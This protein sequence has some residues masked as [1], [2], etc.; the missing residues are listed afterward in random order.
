MSQQTMASLGKS[1]DAYPK[2]SIKNDMNFC[3]WDL[4]TDYQKM[5][6]TKTDDGRSTKENMTMY[7][8]YDDIKTAL[9]KPFKTLLMP[10]STE[11]IEKAKNDGTNPKRK[12]CDIV[13]CLLLCDSTGITMV[14]HVPSDFEEQFKKNDFMSFLGDNNFKTVNVEEFDG[15]SMLKFECGCPIKDIDTLRQYIFEYFKKTQ[16]YVEED[17]DS[18]DDEVMTINDF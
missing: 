18:D 8:S 2:I 12:P 15:Y 11:D 4:R 13:L 10:N 7:L 6:K 9:T 5:V 1:L 3:I 16:I 17:D 14:L